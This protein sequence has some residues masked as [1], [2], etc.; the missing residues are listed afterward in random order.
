MKRVAAA[1]RD[2]VDD[3]AAEA[4]K[5]RA[6]GVGLHAELLHGVNRGRVVQVENRDVVLGVDVGHAIDRHFARGVAATADERRGSGCGRDAGR[7]GGER[8]WVAAVQGEI[9]EA[10]VLNRL[11]DGRTRRFDGRGAAADGDDLRRL[12]ELQ[13]DVD[14]AALLHVDLDVGD[15][16]ALESLLGNRDSV[17]ARLQVRRHVRSVTIRRH[18][19][20]LVRG[21]EDDR[22]VRGGHHCPARVLHPPS[23]GAA[24]LL[25]RERCRR[26]AKCHDDGD[27]DLSHRETLAHCSLLLV[28][29]RV[30]APHAARRRDPQCETVL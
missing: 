24:E 22:H 13:R 20:R 28:A 11:A 26:E 30:A 27:R 6:D 23:H 8:E 12:S 1:L 9:D 18:D 17:G 29:V 10:L 5:F 7:E 4:A 16:G 25:C 15:G 21:H 19:L 2:E 14:A 3:P